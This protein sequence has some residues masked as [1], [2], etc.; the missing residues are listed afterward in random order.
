MTLKRPLKLNSNS[1]LLTL[2][3]KKSLSNLKPTSPR[4]VWVIKI[5]LFFCIYDD[6]MR[7]VRDYLFENSTVTVIVLELCRR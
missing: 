5:V 6:I 1:N 2:P 7:S 3:K 4:L